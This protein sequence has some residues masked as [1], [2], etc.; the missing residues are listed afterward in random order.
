MYVYARCARMVVTIIPY[1]TI[2]TQ[3][4]NDYNYYGTIR[5]IYTKSLNA[6]INICK[7]L[8]KFASCTVLFHYLDYKMIELTEIE[9]HFY[10][11]FLEASLR[12]DNICLCVISLSYSNCILAYSSCESGHQGKHI[13]LQELFLC[14]DHT[15]VESA[16][17]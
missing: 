3:G 7:F 11:I 9:P 2:F 5:N 15:F 6:F 12:M 4:Y 17:L 14:E 1:N 8:H 10:C 16:T 13:S